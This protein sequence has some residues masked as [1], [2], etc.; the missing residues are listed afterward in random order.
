MESFIR[1]FGQTKP[2]EHANGILIAS[3]MRERTFG[4]RKLPRQVLFEQ[5]AN[6]LAEIG[7]L[8]RQSKHRHP[9]VA[10]RLARDGNLHA[11]V[12]SAIERILL[13]RLIRRGFL[14]NSAETIRLPNLLEALAIIR[15]LLRIALR[16]FDLAFHFL[17]VLLVR[18]DNRAE[19]ISM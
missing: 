15:G 16:R 12:V 2:R 17:V 14:R 9:D 7:V 11:L 19:V 5:I 8:R 6:D 18:L 3:P 13:D 4:K 10:R 1:R